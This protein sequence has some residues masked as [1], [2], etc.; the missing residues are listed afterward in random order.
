MTIT[1]TRSAD[2]RRADIRS[3]IGRKTPE[4]IRVLIA[5]RYDFTPEHLSWL[6]QVADRLAASG[7]LTLAD[8][9]DDEFD[10]IVGE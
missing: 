9:T 1:L 8:L 2:Q 4:E 7:Y 5:E 10:D 6:S 3:Q